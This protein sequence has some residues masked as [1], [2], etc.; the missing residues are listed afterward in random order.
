MGRWYWFTGIFD[1]YPKHMSRAEKRLVR[2]LDIVILAFC[3]VQFFLKYLD[4]TNITNAYNSGMSDDLKLFGNELNYFNVTYNCGYMLAQIPMLLALSRPGWARWIFPGAELIWGAITFTQSRAQNA[5]Q[6]YAIR[7]LLGIVEV[8]SFSG[9]N[10]I[11]GSWYTSEEIYKRAGT[12][13]ISSALGS[14]FSGYLQTAA[15]NGLNGVGGM[16]GWRWLFIV[17]GIIT[18]PLA[19]IGF[20]TFPGLPSS[21]KPWFFSDEEHDLALQRMARQKNKVP[22]KITGST[23][24]RV[25]T[26]WRF[27]I[28]IS[29]NMIYNLTSYPTNY[30]SLYL[31]KATDS[32]GH[33]KYTI[34]QVNTIPTGVSAV[35]AFSSWLTASLVNVV[36]ITTLFIVINVSG[37]FC[38]IILRIW[39][40]PEGL[41]FLA[42]FGLG[43]NGANNALMFGL[44]NQICRRDNELRAVAMAGMLMGGWM[45]NAWVPVLEWPT[46][47][48]PRW[49]IGY[50]IQIPMICWLLS[51]CLL[52][53]YLHR[54]Q[55]QW[56][57]KHGEEETTDEMVAESDEADYDEKKE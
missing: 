29:M 28:S 7:F 32:Q 4:S 18:L 11:L 38:N 12:W 31:K 15:Y 49:Q 35:S 53:V 9:T 13:Y 6:L 21:K 43:I 20:F 48:A 2:K 52:A 51:D 25:F 45:L 33:L 40:V 17:D 14:M 44:A 47:D 57:A 10:Y 22:G 23:L 36:P 42:Y 19:F 39:N 56:Y 16:A 34:Q 50:T 37:L 55:E 8:P 46:V 3:C 54:R 27:Y 30:M 24:R 41:K 26:S 5:Q 1:W